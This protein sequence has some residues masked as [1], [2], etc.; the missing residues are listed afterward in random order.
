MNIEA[1]KTVHKETPPPPPLRSPHIKAQ[2][3]LSLRKPEQK[4]L[5]TVHAGGTL[6]EFYSHKHLG[7]SDLS[8]TSSQT[9]W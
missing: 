7:K 6:S 5:I 1:R 4:S 3:D 8:N 9:Y 2:V